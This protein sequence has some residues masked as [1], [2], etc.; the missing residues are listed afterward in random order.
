MQLDDRFLYVQ[1]FLQSLIVLPRELWHP[2]LILIDEAQKFCPEGGR[3]DCANAVISLLTLGRKR[4]YCAVLAT[5]RLSELNKNAAAEC[6]NRLIGRTELDVDQERAGKR[7]G[8]NS[9]TR[10]VLGQLSDGEF[11]GYGPAFGSHEVLRFRGDLPETNPPREGHEIRPPAPSAAIRKI[12]A[13][14][15]DLPAEAAKQATTIEELRD[16]IGGL[17]TQLAAKPHAAGIDQV[18][19]D[20]AIA[21][22]VGASVERERLE[23]RSELLQLK[24]SLGK[25]IETIGRRPFKSASVLASLHDVLEEAPPSSNGVAPDPDD[26]G[27]NGRAAIGAAQKRAIEKLPPGERAV[28][29]AI[30]D[31]HPRP[32]SRDYVSIVCK[33][34]KSSRNKYLDLLKRRGLIVR[35]GE[36]FAASPELFEVR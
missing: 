9:R 34:K 1:N 21:A 33:Y 32:T 25:F 23:H 2:A 30:L 18:A 4:G 31:R 8:M 3:G 16:E 5:Q 10:T 27:G 15:A 12:L 22:A 20:A 28:L 17:K 29:E 7:L 24:S 14:L 6:L 26:V 36:D 13:K 11:F 19:V 35:A